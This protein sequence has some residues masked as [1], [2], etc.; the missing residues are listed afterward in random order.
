MARPIHLSRLVEKMYKRTT[1]N[2]KDLPLDVIE[3]DEKR[4][5]DPKGEIHTK[6]M[7]RKRRRLWNE[8]QIREKM[9]FSTWDIIKA[10]FVK[11]VGATRH[12]NMLHRGIKK[13][14]YDFDV[15]RVVRTLKN[16]NTAMSLF[17]SDSNKLY[18][19]H[20]A[21][22]VIQTTDEDEKIL[23]DWNP[24]ENYLDLSADE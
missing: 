5:D 7:D 12:V 4:A 2:K 15:V 8:L 13:L 23:V 18:L 17:L 16:V 21:N 19:R 10:S 1:E 6:K 14:R 22:N 11:M 20:T 3:E 9:V 24:E